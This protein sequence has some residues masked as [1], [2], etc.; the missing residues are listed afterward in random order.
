MIPSKS[1]S[2]EAEDNKENNYGSHYT[3]ANF[4]VFDE[5]TFGVDAYTESGYFPENHGNS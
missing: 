2:T 4:F 1:S 5:L 3:V